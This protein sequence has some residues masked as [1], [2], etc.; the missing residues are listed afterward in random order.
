M[1]SV[2]QQDQVSAWRVH[3]RPVLDRCTVAGSWIFALRGTL[4]RVTDSSAEG[5]FFVSYSEDGPS[6][7][8]PRADD[9]RPTTVELKASRIADRRVW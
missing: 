7:E 9:K 1:I 5:P 2:G 3:S 6:C 4:P 8:Q